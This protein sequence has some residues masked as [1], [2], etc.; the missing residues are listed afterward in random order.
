MKVKIAKYCNIFY[1]LMKPDGCIVHVQRLL[2]EIEEKNDEL[3]SVEAAVNSF[4]TTCGPTEVTTIA[5]QF[6]SVQKKLQGS[7]EKAQKVKRVIFYFL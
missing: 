1:N 7:H 5:K 4:K 2:K 6:A 3:T